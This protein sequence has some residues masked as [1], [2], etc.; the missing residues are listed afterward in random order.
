MDLRST[1]PERFSNAFDLAHE[2]AALEAGILRHRTGGVSA[3]RPEGRVLRSPDLSFF[4]VAQ[5]SRL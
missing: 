5:P 2:A 3:T 4:Q 1:S